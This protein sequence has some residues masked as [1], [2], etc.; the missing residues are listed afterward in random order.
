MIPSLGLWTL[1]HI[2]VFW[3]ISSVP[4]VAK[5]VP[6]VVLIAIAVFLWAS[7]LLERTVPPLEIIGINWLAV[8]F[9]TLICLL[10]ADLVT[11][12]GFLLRR[13]APRIRGWALLG[14]GAL[15]AIALV[16][17]IRPPVVHDYT[18]RL[19]GLPSREDSTVVVVISDLH[20]GTLLGERWLDTRIAQVEALHPDIVVAL[21]DIVEGHGGTESALVPALRRL[22][23]PL[24][25]W[26]VTGNHEHYGSRG[27]L[28]GPL[29]AAGFTVLHDS[30]AEVRPGLVLAGVDDLTRSRRTGRDSVAVER[31]LAGRPAGA[32]VF[33]S[34]TPWRAE[35]AARAGAGL[36]LAAHTHGG[37]IWPFDYLSATRYPLQA[38][39]YVV[40]GMPVIV[41]RGTGTWGPR[42]RLWRPGEILRVTLRAG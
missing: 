12:F 37:Q 33:L 23:A 36:M 29:D 9:F 22:R 6:R 10:A 26:A 39:W 28:T 27:P 1:A 32:T 31:A 18:V 30:W 20:L 5:R 7:F 35:V 3:R 8:L 2:Y 42:M 41:S 16:Q 34:H 4:V 25:V 15:T 19:A 24:G 21:G 11:G 17:G 14:S 38:G 40:D 13:F